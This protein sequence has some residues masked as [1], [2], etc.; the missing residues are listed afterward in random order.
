MSKTFHIK[1]IVA[2]HGIEILE[3]G[4]CT[5]S[6]A[7]YGG[8]GSLTVRS[9][10]T[11]SVIALLE[12]EHGVISTD[13]ALSFYTGCPEVTPWW[14][15]AVFSHTGR[16]PTR[17]SWQ[18]GRRQW[19]GFS[20][21]SWSRTRQSRSRARPRIIWPTMEWWWLPATFRA[22][23]TSE[24]S[25]ASTACFRSTWGSW[26]RPVPTTWSRSTATPFSMDRNRSAPQQKRDTT[27]LAG[28]RQNTSSTAAPTWSRR[29][30]LAWS[31]NSSQGGRVSRV[32][33]TSA[34][35]R[36]SPSSGWPCC[37]AEM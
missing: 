2:G 30:S 31:W 22:P 32:S 1:S 4:D 20:R 33:R 24:A 9:C 21:Y 34:P 17:L 27:C 8:T 18:P 3:D 15:P 36:I 23:E 13:G 7:T 6:I 29:A 26:K 10:E 5:L 14:S 19:P 16:T 12:W 35:R 25:S 28:A 37:C 11:S